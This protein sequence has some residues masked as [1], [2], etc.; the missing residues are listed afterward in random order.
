[1]QKFKM[2]NHKLNLIVK[3][4]HLSSYKICQKSKTIKNNCKIKKRRQKSPNS[5]I[6]KIN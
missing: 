6:S 2:K 1:M 5:L 4:I 3:F